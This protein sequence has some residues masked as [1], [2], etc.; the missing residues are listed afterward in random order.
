MCDLGILGHYFE[1]KATTIWACQWQK[2]ELLVSETHKHVNKGSKWVNMFTLCMLVSVH[3]HFV[4]VNTSLYKFRRVFL[5]L[6]FASWQSLLWIEISK[7]TREYNWSN[8]LLTET[9]ELGVLVPYPEEGREANDQR[10]PS[11]LSHNSR[12]TQRVRHWIYKLIMAMTFPVFILLIS[13]IYVSLFK[14]KFVKI[15]FRNMKY[16]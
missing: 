15:V 1:Q 10:R 11:V 5:L 7:N 6:M 8:L 3:F 16:V 2:Q 14:D 9:V 12:E 13:E 4:D